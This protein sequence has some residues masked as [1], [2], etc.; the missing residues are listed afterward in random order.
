MFWHDPDSV[1]F[2]LT[3][4][5]EGTQTRAAVEMQKIVKSWNSATLPGFLQV[6]CH[7]KGNYNKKVEMLGI[8]ITIFFLMGRKKETAV[9]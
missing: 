8:Y 6:I 5:K 7:Q 2:D 1:G 9:L 3:W 4:S